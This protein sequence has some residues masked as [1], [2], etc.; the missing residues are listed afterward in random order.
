[1]KDLMVAGRGKIDAC[2]QAPV[3]AVPEA[4][5]G[6]PPTILTSSV[7]HFMKLTNILRGSPI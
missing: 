1:M 3:G 7:Q 4:F 5:R 2:A 6:G